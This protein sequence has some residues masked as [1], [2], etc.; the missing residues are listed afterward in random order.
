MIR[1]VNG[2]K[3]G[4]DGHYIGRAGKGKKGSALANPYRM[5]NANDDEERNRVIARYRQWLWK[6]IQAG[7]RAVLTELQQLLDAARR[8][9]E[10]RLVC[11][12]SPRRCH[13]DVLKARIEWAIANN[14]SFL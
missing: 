14:R 9:E 12:C 5:Q 6:Q 11:F 1:I 4:W 8:N 10:V 7:D 2:Y 3:D 13:G